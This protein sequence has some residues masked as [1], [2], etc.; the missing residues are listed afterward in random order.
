MASGIAGRGTEA[1]QT[2]LRPPVASHRGPEFG[3]VAGHSVLLDHNVG[4]DNADAE[5]L[6]HRPRQRRFI[7]RQN[8][9]RL[10]DRLLLD[11]PAR[12]LVLDRYPRPA[13]GIRLF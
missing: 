9:V 12:H 4:I 8:L 5:F 10:L 13:G 3:R 6:V 1:R 11:D 2:T 7:Q